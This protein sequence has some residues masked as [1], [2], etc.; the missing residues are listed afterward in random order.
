MNRHCS[1]RA[2]E[3]AAKAV[4]AG[5]NATCARTPITRLNE[6][7]LHVARH[8]VAA[9]HVVKATVLEG[10]GVNRPCSSCAF[11]GII[12]ERVLHLADECA[13][14]TSSA[15]QVEGVDKSLKLQV[16][17][18]EGS[19]EQAGEGIVNITYDISTCKKNIPQADMSIYSV[20]TSLTR[21]A[22]VSSYCAPHFLGSTDSALKTKTLNP[23]LDMQFL[24]MQ[25]NFLT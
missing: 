12:P 5:V 21:N 16:R 7:C 10:A 15:E 20:E 3:C 8:C 24:D 25:C 17:E 6:T 11:E 14:V 22:T 9:E 18:N 23:N 4:A 2:I 13:R 19:A 1:T